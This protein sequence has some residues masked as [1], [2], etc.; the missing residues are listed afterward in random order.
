MDATR[1]KLLSMTSINGIP[2]L[3]SRAVVLFH[4]INV[5]EREFGVFGLIGTNEPRR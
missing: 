2:K 3:S 4:D 1:T 5:R